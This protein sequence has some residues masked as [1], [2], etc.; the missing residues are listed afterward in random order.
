MDNE[1]ITL[2]HGDAC[3][4]DLRGKALHHVDHLE[5]AVFAGGMHTGHPSIM[6]RVDLPDGRHVAL[7]ESSLAAFLTA[8]DAIK[9]RYGDPR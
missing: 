1:A 3:W 5:L 9:A 4:P 7:V 8:V 6:L 2:K